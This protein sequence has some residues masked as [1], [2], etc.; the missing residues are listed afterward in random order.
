M[1]G[2]LIPTLILV[3][4]TLPGFAHADELAQIIQQDLA[5]LGYEPGNTRGEVTTETIVA[6]SKFQA[7][8][9][10]AVTGEIT[11]QLAGVIKAALRQQN[12]PAAAS[13]TPPAN[14][15][16]ALDAD[17]LRAAQ[18]ACLQEKMAAAQEAQQ[19]QRGL[20]SLARAVTRTVSQLGNS[21]ASRQISRAA[22]DVYGAG[23]IAGDLQSAAKDLGLT[24]DEVEQ[25][26]N[27]L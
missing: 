7:E 20:R 9:D 3:T 13:N 17:A 25:C 19:R 26:R 24:E 16:P 4:F 5:T 18:Q 22:S 1:S 15:A 21:D 27:P 12:E 23:A 8:H 11:P 14:A 10:L 2:R 6:V